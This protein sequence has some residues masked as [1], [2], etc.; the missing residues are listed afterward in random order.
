MKSRLR[1]TALLF[2]APVLCLP[3]TADSLWTATG[4]REQGIAT[5]IKAARVGDILT[6]VVSENAAQSS[7]QS[8]DTNSTTN[9]NGAVTQF[10]FPSTV[11]GLGT[12]KGQL[13]GTSFSNTSSFKGGGDISNTQS[14]TASAAVL[15]TDVLPNGNLVIAGARRLIFSGETQ[16]VILHGII[17]PADIGTDNTVVSSNIAEA[18]IEFLSDGNITDAQKRGWLTNL[19][20]KLRPF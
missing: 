3:L 8:K 15:I 14:V 5:D 4:S 7:S 17:R 16:N 9:V 2:L 13:P 10:L 6:V 11:S 19:Y 20:E 12:L 1:P 18:S